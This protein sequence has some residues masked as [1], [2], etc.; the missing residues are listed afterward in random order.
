MQ[1]SKSMLQDSS[2]CFLSKGQEYSVDTAWLFLERQKK[3]A[4]WGRAKSFVMGVLLHRE[5]AC[6]SALL[7]RLVTEAMLVA[8]RKLS[9]LPVMAQQPDATLCF[10]RVRVPGVWGCKGYFFS[11]VLGWFGSLSF[12][13]TSCTELTLKLWP[14]LNWLGA[15]SKIPPK[16]GRQHVRWKIA[17]LKIQLWWRM[18]PWMSHSSISF[19]YKEPELPPGS[20]AHSVSHRKS[21]RRGRGEI[22]PRNE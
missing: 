12:P 13:I 1:H 3:C 5:L 19:S 4:S 9:E 18:C 8:P 17:V 10:P 14:E 11:R 20:S 15:V 22:T 2:L 16:N 7:L 21:P 6:L